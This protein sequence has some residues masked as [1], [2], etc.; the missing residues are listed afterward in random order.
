[1]N[2][3]EISDI[4]FEWVVDYKPFETDLHYKEYAKYGFEKGYEEAMKKTDELLKA[5]DNAR[6]ICPFTGDVLI[7]FSEI[8]RERNKLR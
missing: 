4:A 3:K 6:T 2:H 7:N 5:I 8:L 1:M